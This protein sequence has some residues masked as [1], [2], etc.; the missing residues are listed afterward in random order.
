MLSKLIKKTALAFSYS[1]QGIS[2]SKHHVI[3]CVDAHLL[4]NYGKIMNNY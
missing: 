2:F 4:V 3:A 1:N